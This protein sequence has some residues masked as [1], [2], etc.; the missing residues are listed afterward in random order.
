LFGIQGNDDVGRVNISALTE[1][2]DAV[3]ALPPPMEVSVKSF[4]PDLLA[5]MEDEN[6]NNNN[7]SNN[8]QEPLLNSNHNS[9]SDE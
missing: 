5:G 3:S 8:L 2:D 4:F 6:N 7:N 1:D 9:R